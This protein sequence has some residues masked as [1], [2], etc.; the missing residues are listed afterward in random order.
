MACTSFASL[1]QITCSQKNVQCTYTKETLRNT[2]VVPMQLGLAA[3]LD[4]GATTR[5]SKHTAS[6]CNTTARPRP[7][8]PPLLSPLPSSWYQHSNN[9]VHHCRYHQTSSAHQHLPQHNRKTT[10]AKIHVTVSAT[11]PQHTA[12]P[13][14]RYRTHLAAVDCDT[15]AGKRLLYRIPF[16]RLHPPLLPLPLTPSR[17]Y[18]PSHR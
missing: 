18:N 14:S 9:T 16:L 15:C 10:T 17:G 3:S 1:R 4:D 8:P 6:E 12:S 7:S 13:R 2:W 11:L 5:H